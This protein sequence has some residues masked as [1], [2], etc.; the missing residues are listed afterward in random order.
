MTRVCMT[1]CG[2]LATLLI[3]STVAQAQELKATMERATPA[4]PGEGIGSVTVSASPAGAVFKL[5]LKGLPP[6]PHGF[7]VHAN[8]ACGPTTVNNAPVP[9]GAAG[10]HWDADN[11]GKHEGPSGHGHSGDLPVLEVAADGT[12]AQSLTAPRIKDLAALKG[13]ALIIHA[14]G[15]NYSDQPAA[16]GG[17]GARLACGVID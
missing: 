1:I 15:D 17:G 14:G 16:L 11:T 6:G 8:G 12:A 5:A 13:H 4:G 10:G 9:A 3:A 7:H 2:A